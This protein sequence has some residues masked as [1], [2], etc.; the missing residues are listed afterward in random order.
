MQISNVTVIFISVT[1][2]DDTLTVVNAMSMTEDVE[3]WEVLGVLIGIREPKFKFNKIQQQCK[4]PRTQK[5][6][7]LTL[8]YDTHPYASWGLLHQ[9]LSMMG[10]TKAAQEI[11]EKYLQ[12]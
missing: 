5:E 9:A 11:Q 10:E 1:L 4:D 8:W 7:L 12:G 6:A 3:E 2:P